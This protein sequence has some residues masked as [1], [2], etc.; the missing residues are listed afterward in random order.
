MTKS[1]MN[2]AGRTISF[3]QCT[4]I[5]ASILNYLNNAR[6]SMTLGFRVWFNKR[7][8]NQVFLRIDADISNSQV[9]TD[10][11]FSSNERGLHRGKGNTRSN[12]QSQRETPDS[13]G[14]KSLTAIL[15]FFSPSTDHAACFIQPVAKTESR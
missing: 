11:R 1:R 15:N 13:A 4:F 2:N 3:L 6:L 12:L 14:C 8:A 7:L 9:A 10:A 5:S